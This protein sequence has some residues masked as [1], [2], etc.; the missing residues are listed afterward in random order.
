MLVIFYGIGF[1]HASF[2][3]LLFLIILSELAITAWLMIRIVY[4]EEIKSQIVNTI[5]IKQRDE[6][7]LV[8]EEYAC[9]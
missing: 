5:E 6:I 1:L 3:S 7:A 9:N 8:N 2:F 4:N